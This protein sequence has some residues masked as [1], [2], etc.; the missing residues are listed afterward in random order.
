ML[1]AF[2]HIP[3]VLAANTTAQSIMVFNNDANGQ[4]E[5]AAQQ[6]VLLGS[7]TWSYDNAVA[8]TYFTNAWDGNDPPAPTCT[9]PGCPPGHVTWIP[10]Y[11][12]TPDAPG[13]PEALANKLNPVV[14]QNSCT[15]FDGGTLT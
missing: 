9:G 1:A 14:G 10:N 3:H 15:F 4:L 11:C 8:E 12:S 5:L 2:A 6:F 7:E 13:A